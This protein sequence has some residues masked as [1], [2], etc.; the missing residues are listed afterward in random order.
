MCH[1]MTLLARHSRRHYLAQCEHGTIHLVWLH[2]T[3][4]MSPDLLMQLVDVLASWLDQQRNET[5]PIAKT[6][7]V[8]LALTEFDTYL[9]WIEH[10][11]LRLNG[12]EVEL[13]AQLVQTT[14]QRLRKMLVPASEKTALDT[15]VIQPL[16]A[17]VM[18]D[19]VSPLADAGFCHELSALSARA[20]SQN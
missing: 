11:A 13:L 16:P 3:V 12:S 7:D 6:R 19:R 9:L 1:Y 20:F 4:H 5:L 17:T 8:Q 2:T 14:D 15:T 10:I 18:S